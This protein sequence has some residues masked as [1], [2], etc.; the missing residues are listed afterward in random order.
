MDNL[1]KIQQWLQ[2]IESQCV[3]PP[4]GPPEFIPDKQVFEFFLL[5]LLK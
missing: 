5:S 2:T 1:T 4:F 3:V